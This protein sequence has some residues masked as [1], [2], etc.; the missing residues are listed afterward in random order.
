MNLIRVGFCAMARG[1]ALLAILRPAVAEP[2]GTLPLSTTFKGRAT[3]DTLV[4][5]AQKEKWAAL[6]MG[7][8]VGRFGRAMAGTPYVGFSLEIH[9]HIEAPSVNFNGVDCWTFFEIA[10]GMARMIEVPRKTYEPQHLLAEIETTRYRAGKCGGD[11]LDRIHYLVDWYHDNEARG[12]LENLTR[13][14][15][16][17]RMLKGRKCSEMTELWMHYRYLK[18]SPKARSGMKKHEARVSKLPVYYIPTA[19]VP[20]MESKIEEGDILGIVTRKDG[21]FCSH[22]GLAIEGS[23]GRMHIIHASSNFKKVVDEA[24]ISGYLNK[25]SNHMGLVVGRPLP[26]AN[27]VS[28][29]RDY[30]RNLRRLKRR[31]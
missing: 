29:K 15:G 20:S 18:H 27:T 23:G 16:K 3:F 2:A 12:T 6:P 14:L 22:V 17:A 11:Y 24:T 30:Q 19:S 9:D 5:R 8:R 21:V 28:G 10:L 26:R 13:S 7:Q 31:R 1:L 25:Y 4:K